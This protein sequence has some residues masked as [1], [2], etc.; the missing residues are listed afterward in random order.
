MCDCTGRKGYEGSG[1]VK[2]LVNRSVSGTMGRAVPSVPLN[3]ISGA[4]VSGFIG[5][6]EAW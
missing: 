1:I 4:L 5:S 6:L 3:R 2:A